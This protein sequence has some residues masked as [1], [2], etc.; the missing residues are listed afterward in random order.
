MIGTLTVDVIE[1]NDLPS[2]ELLRPDPFAIIYIESQNQKTQYVKSTHKPAWRE[3]FSFYVTQSNAELKIVLY[4]WEKSGNHR[5]LGQTIIPF[6][7][8]KNK[9]KIDVWHE[10]LPVPGAK[11]KAKGSIHISYR[12]DA[13]NSVKVELQAVEDDVK[14]TLARQGGILQEIK[15]KTMILEEKYGKEIP[16]LRAQLDIERKNLTSTNDTLSKTATEKQKLEED[17]L[18]LRD[19]RTTL[20]NEKEAILK[21]K[22]QFKGEELPN[23]IKELHD[24]E[25][26]MRATLIK[27]EN[28]KDDILREHK[29]CMMCTDKVRNMAF[30]PCGHVCVCELCVHN[31]KECLICKAAIHQKIKVVV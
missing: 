31:A 29:L 22:R 30:I 7:A 16:Y 25:V 21:E 2:K 23:T 11:E 27:I 18:I 10:L 14:Q 9:E 12:F 4:D 5:P 3:T 6:T 15:D 26:I 20:E 1:A 28:K 19:T 17:I 13:E 24:L 8:F